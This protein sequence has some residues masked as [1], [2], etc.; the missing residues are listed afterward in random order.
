MNSL[1]PQHWLGIV[2]SSAVALYGVYRYLDYFHDINFLGGILLLEVIAVCVWKFNERYLVL[3]IVAFV[4]AGTAVPLSGPWNGGRWV[5]LG[6]GTAVG[7]IVWTKA[8]LKPSGSLHLVAF[9]CMCAAFVS[10]TVSLWVQMAGLKALSLTLLF[11]YCGSGAR[12]A[13][14]GREDKFFRALLG[15]CEI[16]LYGTVICYFVF[17]AHVWGNPNAL[18]AAMSVGFFPVLLWGWYITPESGAKLRRL[19]ALLL[20]AYLVRFSLA[21]AGMLAVALV[22]VTFCLCLYQYRMLMKIIASLLVLILLG[23]IFSSGGMSGQFGDLKDEMLYK[24]HKE[25]G[26]FGSRQT[27]WDTTVATIKAHPWFGTGYGTSPT[28]DEPVWVGTTRSSAETAREH[29]SSYMTITEWVGL[30]GV[31]PFAVLIAL[32]IFNVYKV[33]AWVRRTA[34]PRHYSVPVAMI[35]MAGLIHAS[36]EDWMFAVGSYLCLF[37][38]IFVFLLEDLVPSTSNLPHAAAVRHPRPSTVPLGVAVP[39]LPSR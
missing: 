29:G 8:T 37:F 9:F 20:C 27:P 6:V 21:R 34:N 13:L 25:E 22:T 32:T 16:A 24:G 11:V 39:H 35:V 2:L 4:W 7:F 23:G 36:F 28:G 26:V 3:L 14:F 12:L 30:L 18:G 17:G 38:W 19:V 31:L 1:K 5:V 33:F 15:A 10:A